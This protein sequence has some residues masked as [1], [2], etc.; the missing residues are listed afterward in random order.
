[1]IPGDQSFFCI[2]HNSSFPYALDR[3]LAPLN[4]INDHN[5][6]YLLTMDYG[7]MISHN[8]IRQLYVLDW[9]MK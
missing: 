7:P 9:L 1:M 2:I 3:E 5:P 8:G 6:K 4:A